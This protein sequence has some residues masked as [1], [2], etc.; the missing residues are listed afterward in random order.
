MPPDRMIDGRIMAGKNG[1]GPPQSKTLARM[2]TAHEPREVSWSAP[3]PWRFG[4]GVMDARGGAK[5]FHLFDDEHFDW[6]ICRH[7]F[8][9]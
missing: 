8:K 7:E 5:L 6:H 2:L 9:T 4:T 1:G 3:V